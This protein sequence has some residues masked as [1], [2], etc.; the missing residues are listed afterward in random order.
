MSDV[1]NYA[2]DLL[3]D[4]Y[5]AA[6]PELSRILGNEFG[7]D[8]VALGIR[9][10]FKPD[11][12]DRVSEMLRSPMRR[13][14]MDR[15]EDEVFGIEHLWNIVNG[16]WSLFKKTFEDKSR[17]QV[18]LSEITELRNN[19]AH[20]KKRHV[21]LRSNL[22]RTIGS[23][24]VILSALQ[25]P[26]AD[27]FAEI[28]DSLS[29]GATPWG[30]FL[31]GYLPPSDE[32]YPEFI[33]RP[34]ELDGLSGWLASDSPQILV[35][36]YGGVGKSALA[37]KF[38]REVRD[39]SNENLIAVCWVSAKKAEFSEGSV[40]E[41]PADFAD[42]PSF[43]KALWTAM[44]GPS[45]MPSDLDPDRL[46]NELNDMPMLL[47]VDDFDTI[48]EDVELTEFLLYKLR[49]TPTRVIYTS[50][51]RIPALQNLEVP[52]FS[53]NELRDFVSR[54][55]VDY[56]VDQSACL[57]RLKGIKSVTGG[58]PLFADDLIHHAAFVGLDAAL[59]DWSQRKGDA[60]RQYA[61][62][63]QIEYLSH[64]S[65]EVLIALSV[66]NRAL[67]IVEISAVAG[68][69]DDDAQA[70]IGELL[71]WRMV[72]QVKEG[73]SESP[74]FRMN[75]NT[76]RLVQ[77][78]FRDD[79]RMKTFSAA[80]RA[81]TGERVPE[82]K[83]IAIA[84]I[85]SRTMELVRTKSSQ[86]AEEHLVGSMTGELAD[87]PDLFGV[88]GRLRSE[89]QPLNAHAQLARDAF[90]RAHKLGSSKVDTYYHWALLERKLAESMIANATEM[91][92]TD[93][94]I[95][96]QWKAC[97]DVAVRGVERCGP[98]QPL[99]Y[100]AGYGASR[101]AKARSLAKSFLYAEGAYTRSID[102]F[103]RALAAPVSDIAPIP[104]GLVYRGMTLTSEGLG[105]EDR[106]RRTLKLWHASSGSEHH[107][108]RE[109]RRLL[110]KYP[111]LRTVPEF[112][113]MWTRPLF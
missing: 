14:N 65:G 79:G 59:R 10:H 70:G 88:L 34:S 41:R 4:F 57:K 91:N 82:A 103:N 67:R 28:V 2:T 3:L 90:E 49:S 19:L 61:L 73:D 102:W 50:R 77:Q 30:A 86:A 62:Q 76:S 68:L 47:V 83:K 101:E 104:R 105:D 35:C 89:R 13:V 74:V 20:R 75:N 111:T 11:Y 45:E 93:N 26:R 53:G 31:E 96:D 113:P 23:C 21:L 95:A 71:R 107:F 44:Y 40:R 29:S 66:A 80:F 36:G 85:V 110:Q 58:Y 15:T 17:T 109:C 25:S 54:R 33:G 6:H 87:S 100:F 78:P 22:L 16:N 8:W 94:A 48:S 72:N 81:L 7:G 43:V 24:Q 51:H 92:I 60:A 5:D 99:F 9:K 69:T 55:A 18:Y 38:A 12:F 97:E 39:S 1:N 98:S 63:R 27:T 106:L 64:S 42:L 32:M 37:Y 56:S 112:G 84:K 46:L 108:E 52:P